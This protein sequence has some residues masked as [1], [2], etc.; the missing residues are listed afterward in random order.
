M[1]ASFQLVCCVTHL[2]SDLFWHGSFVDLCLHQLKSFGGLG[3]ATDCKFSTTMS[4]CLFDMAKQLPTIKKVVKNSAKPLMKATPKRKACK[5]LVAQR[6]MFAGP[7]QPVDQDVQCH[8][9]GR[10]RLECPYLDVYFELQESVVA[11]NW[12][13]DDET[14]LIPEDEQLGKMNNSALMLSR[15]F[16][17]PTYYV[18][19][20]C[21]R[22]WDCNLGHSPGLAWLGSDVCLQCGA[23]TWPGWPIKSRCFHDA[24]E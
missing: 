20:G 12:P 3:M 5:D 17:P 2:C 14:C 24:E 15:H 7:F 11:R 6:F 10:G 18:C 4:D 8:M 1:M 13:C 9:C 19:E 21:C 16:G 23:F 22:E